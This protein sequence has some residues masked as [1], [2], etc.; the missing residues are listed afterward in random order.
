MSK[1]KIERI[2]K[3]IANILKEC[4]LAV[5]IE[6]NL[7]TIYFLD[8]TFDLTNKIYRQYRKT[9]NNPLYINKNFNH[10]SCILKTIASIN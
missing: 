2:K 1:P 5:I 4:G 8:V 9:N 6:C 3:T 10:P 7:K